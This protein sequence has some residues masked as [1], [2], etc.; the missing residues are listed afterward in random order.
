[1]YTIRIAVF[2]LLA[3]LAACAPPEP[4]ATVAAPEG[5]WISLFNGRNLEG[6]TVK[7]AGLEVGD[8]YRN[9]FR[10]EDGLLKVS[11]QQYDKFAD[12]FGSLYYNTPFS[13]YWI[14]AQYRF[15]GAAAPG[16]PGW[17]YK[18]SG[19]QLHSQSPASMRKDQ[20]FPV[21]VEFDL[22]GGWFVGSRPTGDV[23]HYGTR[24]LIA[25]AP[26]KGLCSKLSDITIRGD[27][28]VTVLAE[29]DGGKR[30]KQIVNGTQVVEYT[31]VTLDDSNADAQRLLAQGAGKALTAGYIS[32]QSNGFPI[33]FRSLE[34]LPLDPAPEPTS[35][36]APAPAPAAAPAQTPAQ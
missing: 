25:G 18:N 3:A 16:A 7:I 33:E 32:V 20:Q 2:A 26:A 19:L 1:M 28:W 12:R 36:A 22:V 34:I 15:V 5:N 17:T 31:D 8:N 23:C 6:W 14:R 4:K 9:T 27:Q 35:A 13:H 11:Y 10:V 21:S 29:V 30:I 24:I